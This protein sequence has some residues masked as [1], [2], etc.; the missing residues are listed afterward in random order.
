MTV[1]SLLADAAPEKPKKKQAR[2]EHAD[3]KVKLGLLGFDCKCGAKFC[4]A[5]RHPESHDC[6]YNHKAAGAAMLTKQLVGC[7]ADKL[8]GDR[9]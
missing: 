4:G 9:I 6:G 1:K 8:A 7:V 5:H 3:C 2:C